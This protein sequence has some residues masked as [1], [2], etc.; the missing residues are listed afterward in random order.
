MP[1]TRDELAAR[2]ARELEDGTY[3]NLG[4][5]LPTL[6]PNHLPDGI[7]VV[8]H[9]ENGILGVGPYPWEGEEDAEA[10]QR[11]QGDRHRAARRE[12]LRLGGELRHDPRRA[13]HDRGAR[14]HAGLGRAATSPTGRCPASSSRAWA[15]RWTS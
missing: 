3:V 10:H 5:G 9:S 14:R 15:A 11:G 8:L 12:L 4:I 2:A 7:H 6:I 13:R 1:L